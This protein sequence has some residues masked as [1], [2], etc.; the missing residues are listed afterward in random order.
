GAAAEEMA[1]VGAWAEDASEWPDDDPGLEGERTPRQWGPG[2]LVPAPVGGPAPRPGAAAGAMALSAS[3]AMP[4]WSEPPS[5]AE[6]GPIAW[7]RAKLDERPVRADRSRALHDEPTGRLD[8][9]DLWLVTVL[10]ASILGMRMFRLSEPYQMHF[11]E[12][13]HA[14]TATEFLQDW[15]YGISHDIYEWTHPHLAKYAMAGG[16]VAWGDDRV[17]ATSDLGVPVR[18]AIIEPRRDI[19][20]L[21]GGRGGDRVHIVTGTEL[22]SYDLL[23]RSLVYTAPIPGASSLAYDDVGYRLFVGTDDG[24][25]LVF[26]ASGLDGVTSPELAA[27]VAPPSAFGHVDGGIAQLYASSDGRTLLVATKDGR[28]VTLDADSAETIGDVKIDGIKA[29]APGGTGPVV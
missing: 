25:I 3:L 11:D 5:L 12:V 23:D 22:R 24:Q 17:G 18:A 14:R 28:L 1:G 26:D 15:R 13:Y 4:T 7:F 2:A 9:L 6:L 27:L 8:K 16:L 29:F 21:T 19:P 20:R 10:V